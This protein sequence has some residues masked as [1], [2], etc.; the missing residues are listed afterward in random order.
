[1][2]IKSFLNFILV[3]LFALTT[4][5]G[6]AQVFLNLETQAIW[7]T[8]NEFGIPG[9]T[10]TRVDTADFDNGPVF[11][12]RAYAG[13]KWNN[14]HEIRALYAPLSVT[15]TVRFTTDVAFQESIFNTTS[16]TETFY[17]FNSYRLGYTYFFNNT[18]SWNWGLG[19]TAKIRDAEI[20]L[21]Q[22]TTESSKTN[23]GFVPLLR[24]YGATF[25]G[26]ETRLS[27]DVEGL[28]A[29][30][31]RAIDA[32]LKL[33]HLL[34]YFGAGHSLW[35]FLGYRTVEGGADNDEVFNFAWFHFASVG[36]H[37]DF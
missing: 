31:G 14:K 24:F 29:P 21:T 18:G 26:D 17:K 19:F 3:S 7:Q 27:L 22:G 1:M 16:D 15:S 35:G 25:L 30:Q 28:G 11:G 2:K 13:F 9:T 34:G 37:A 23:V 10:G 20:R 5:T 33:E 32:S 36:F 4:Q 8:R 12:Y 6:K